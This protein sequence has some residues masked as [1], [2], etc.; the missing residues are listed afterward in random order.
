MKR[1]FWP[2]SDNLSYR[3]VGES[4]TDVDD[5]TWH[6]T[7]RVCVACNGPLWVPGLTAKSGCCP[8]GHRCFLTDEWTSA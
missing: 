1:Q 4:F 6:L 5:I 7:D 2:P 3:L 8:N